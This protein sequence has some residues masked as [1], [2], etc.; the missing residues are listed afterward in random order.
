MGPNPSRD[1]LR[2]D[3]PQASGEVRDA[4]GRLKHT[5]ERASGFC[6][7][8]WEAGVCL[9]TLDDGTRWRWVRV[10]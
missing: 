10:D 2:W 1:C 5:F 8:G 3:G 6:S 7:E 4:H 9:I